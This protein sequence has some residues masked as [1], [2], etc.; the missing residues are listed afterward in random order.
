MQFG[1][2]LP[3]SVEGGE[4]PLGDYPRFDN[5]WTV[6]DLDASTYRIESPREATGFLLD[7]SQPS[8]TTW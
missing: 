3:L 2:A 7:F 5:P 6:T 8:R 4:V 1:W